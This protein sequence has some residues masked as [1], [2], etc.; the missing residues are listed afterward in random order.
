MP[1]CPSCDEVFPEGPHCPRCRSPL[2]DDPDAA[3]RI[4]VPAAAQLPQLKV[5]RRLRRAFGG[6]SVEG[7]P[8][9]SMLALALACLLFAA[10]FLL[11][12]MGSLVP[13][14]PVVVGLS[15]PPLGLSTDGAVTYVMRFSGLGDD[16]GLVRHDL[17]T[18]DIERLAR[19]TLPFGTG[20]TARARPLIVTSG[21]SIAIVVADRAG[22]AHV[23]AYASQRA[24]PLWVEG[25]AAA[26]E[27]P[28]SLLVL[29]EDKALMRYAMDGSARP[30][31]VKGTW[32]ELHAAG[33]AAVL[34]ASDGDGGRYLVVVTPKGM[35]E[36]IDV[37]DEATILAAAPDG[38][39]VLVD[40][41]LEPRLWDGETYTVLRAD[42]HQAVAGAFSDDSQRVAVTLIERGRPNGSTPVWLGVAGISGR[43]A[44]DEVTS[45]ADGEGCVAAPAWASSGRWVYMAPGDGSVYAIEAGGSPPAGVATRLLGCGVGFAG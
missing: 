27:T 4:D 9:R 18:G 40:V 22:G 21:Q 15:A 14:G 39:R 1:W 11:G 34:V 32:L 43:V 16:P 36:T 17:E 24:F 2:V 10:G 3:R 44:F 45:W 20:A 7:A 38:S 28:G 33:H 37:P 42:Q 31:A 29:G 30:E 12:R 8:P 5:P 23:G 41:D 19:F 13:E 35:R 6:R 25:V 26:W